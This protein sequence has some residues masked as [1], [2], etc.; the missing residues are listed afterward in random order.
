MGEIMGLVF[1]LAIVF[2]GMCV[3]L[4]PVCVFMIHGTLSR[5]LRE[6]KK[7]NTREDEAQLRG[8]KI[9][10]NAAKYIFKEGDY[11]IFPDGQEAEIR[12]LPQMVELCAV[13]FNDRVLAQGQK[14]FELQGITKFGKKQ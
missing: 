1:L 13:T 8:D 14:E 10:T 9:I 7:V 3:I 5:C 6:L 2:Y 11:V 4:L 12:Q